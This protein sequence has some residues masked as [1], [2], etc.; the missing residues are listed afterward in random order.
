MVRSFTA[1]VL[2]AMCGTLPSCVLLG[3]GESA[4]AHGRCGRS[5]ITGVYF[6]ASA[7][8][9]AV[10]AW[11]AGGG[12]IAGGYFYGDWYDPGDGY[13]ASTNSGGLT[14]DPNSDDGSGWDQPDD[15]S[16]GD[17]GADPGSDP[18]GDT[19]GAAVTRLHLH[20][21]TATPLPASSSSASPASPLPSS[22]S[23]PSPSPSHGIVEGCFACTMGCRTDAVASPA[24]RQA[25]GVSDT[26]QA[27]A[28][29]SAVRTLAQ[30]SHDTR[31]ERL[32][33]CQQME[34]AR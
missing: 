2:L 29:A 19:G 22:S 16:Q 24:G 14:T 28:C 8:A 15:G 1:L 23:S 10:G 12:A 5:Y 11:Y 30:W 33:S 26:S 32:V 4:A 13:D 21:V 9:G 17:P 18:S 3:G 7:S 20:G 25:V 31:R 6:G 27:D 34:A